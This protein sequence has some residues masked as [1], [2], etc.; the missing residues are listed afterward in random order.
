MLK[1]HRYLSKLLETSQVMYPNSAWFPSDPCKVAIWRA[2]PS[3]NSGI[4][5][6]I[7]N[8]EHVII[9]VD[10]IVLLIIG[11]HGGHSFPSSNF[12][13]SGFLS[14]GTSLVSSSR[15]LPTT[16]S[17]RAVQQMLGLVG[18][19]GFWG[20]DLGWCLLVVG[21]CLVKSVELRFSNKTRHLGGFY[22][23][24]SKEMTWYSLL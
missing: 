8:H 1:S 5:K 7:T 4:W 21:C 11:N 20:L 18:D 13:W 2:S 19:C 15:I 3:S 24:F 12:Q 9:L 10:A 17:L 6:T 23:F 22:V 16:I 14:A